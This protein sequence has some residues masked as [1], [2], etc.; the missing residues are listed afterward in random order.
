LLTISC[1]AP[2]LDP[3]EIKVMYVNAIPLSLQ[4]IQ[5]QRDPTKQHLLKDIL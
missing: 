4:Q 1:T 5:V 3:N 2:K